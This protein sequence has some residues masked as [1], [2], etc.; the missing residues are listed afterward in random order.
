MKIIT[1]LVLSILLFGCANEGHMLSVNQ[2]K[3]SHLKTLLKEKKFLENSMLMYPGA[4]DEITRVQAEQIINTA[5]TSILSTSKTE[6]SEETFWHHLEVAARQLSMMDSEEMDRGLSYF[7]Q[8][9]DIFEIESSGGRL[10]D[11]RYGFDPS[12]P[13]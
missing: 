1:I 7:E 10:N 9:M 8:M 3:V 2:E 12:T 13:H 5:I 4:P 11:W 6:I